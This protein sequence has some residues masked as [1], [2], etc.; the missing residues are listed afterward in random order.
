[1]PQKND[2]FSQIPYKG[3]SGKFIKTEKDANGT[4]ELSNKTFVPGR[5]SIV[6]PNNLAS[7]F[8]LNKP[9]PCPWTLSLFAASDLK[10]FSP[11]RPTSAFVTKGP[12][13]SILGLTQ[14]EL[15]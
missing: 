1:M 14:V 8:A 12:I 2:Q 7:L 3:E 4:P 15:S 5:K 11:S 6:A 10:P 13:D 9:T